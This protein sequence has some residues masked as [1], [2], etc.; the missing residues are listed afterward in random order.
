MKAAM[1]G[2]AWPPVSGLTN[3]IFQPWQA[4]GPGRCDMRSSDSRL[5]A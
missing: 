2:M 1:V 4:S 3:C 5:R